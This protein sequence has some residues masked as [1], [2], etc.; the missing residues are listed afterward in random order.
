MWGDVHNLAEERSDDS[1][2]CV[3]GLVFQF[4]DDVP[5]KMVLDFPVSWNGL[6]GTRAGI[7][8]PIMPTAVSDENATALLELADEVNPF[9]AN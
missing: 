9:H 3:V 1:Q 5:G 7:L 8:I 6:T 4:P 2:N